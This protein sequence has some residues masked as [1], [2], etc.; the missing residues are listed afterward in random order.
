MIKSAGELPL[1]EFPTREAREIIEAAQ[2]Q[3]LQVRVES[4]SFVSYLP[5]DLTTGCAWLIED[6]A[7][8]QAVAEAM[9]AE[10]VPVQDIEA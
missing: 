5:F 9:M 7:E 1:G 3:G 6:E 10:G 8:A 2:A 4:D